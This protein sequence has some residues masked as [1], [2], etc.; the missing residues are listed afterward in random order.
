MKGFLNPGA[1]PANSSASLSGLIAHPEKILRNKQ[2]ITTPHVPQTVSIKSKK[3]I[4]PNIPP[5]ENIS[6]PPADKA[7]GIPTKKAKPP[8]IQAAFFLFHFFFR[9]RKLLYVRIPA[10]YCSISQVHLSQI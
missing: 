6:A 1:P 8:T 9:K 4:S 7:D 3:L 10:F 5:A 2:T